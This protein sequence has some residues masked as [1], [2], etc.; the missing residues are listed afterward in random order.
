MIIGNTKNAYVDAYV[1]HRGVTGSGILLSVHW[2]NEGRNVR[3]LVDAGAVQ[4]KEN[5]GFYNCFFPFNAGKIDFIILTH[6]HHDHQGLLPVVV[7]QGFQ[8]PI[9]THY[10]TSNLMNVS[11]YDSC[12]IADPFIN[13]PLCTENEVEKTLDLVVGCS[14]KKIM[15]PDKNIR[16]VFY[17]NGHLVGAV[18]TLV[19]ISSPGEEDI[20]LLFTG[21]YKDNNIFFNVE[22]PPKQVRDLNISAIFCES[23]YG[24]VDSTNPIFEKCLEKNTVKALQEGKTVIYPA[25]AQGRYQEILYDI[26]MWKKKGIIPERTLVYADGGTSQDFTMRYMYNDLG[27]KKL[28]KDFV[29]KGTK[30]VPRSRDRMVY[31]REIMQNNQPKIII[32]PGG[33]G[34]YGPIQTY[35]NEYL[36]RDDA[37]IHFLGYCSPDSKG[38]QLLNTPTGE[39]VSYGGLEY[40]KRCDVLKTGEMSG[41][42]PRNK[43]LNLIKW[44]PNTKSIIVN[45]GE[46]L[47][48]Q[49]FRQYLLENLSLSEDQI[50]T[51]TPEIAYRI[52]SNGIADWLPTN[53][54]SIL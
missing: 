24:D 6:G 28:M 9:F 47:T 35:I 44:F 48:K 33:M 42:A 34:S 22:M 29:P 36:S 30:F 54:E 1:R 39:K 10:A 20:N 50:V 46:E 16:I 5:N 14:T 51:A 26:K 49:K 43:L 23:T 53:F 40:I 2:R 18:L 31:R 21:D 17:S 45:H 12:K 52:E 41:H 27:I 13:E 8:G 25:F 15:K 11:L 37:L 7:R 3:F 38:Y 19:V 4:G 32:A